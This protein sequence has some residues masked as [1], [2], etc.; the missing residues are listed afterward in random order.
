MISLISNLTSTDSN[1]ISNH[2]E[3]I[4]ILLLKK[5]KF[6]NDVIFLLMEFNIIYVGLILMKFHNYIATSYSLNASFKLVFKSVEG[7]RVPIINAQGT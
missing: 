2:N 5:D 6:K 4:I 3:M 7:L 1:A